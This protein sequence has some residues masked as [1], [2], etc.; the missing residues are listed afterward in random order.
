MSAKAAPLSDCA[1]APESPLK[2]LLWPEFPW[3]RQEHIRAYFL[4]N[5]FLAIGDV[6]IAAQLYSQSAYCFGSAFW[7]VGCVCWAYSPA[8]VLLACPDPLSLKRVRTEWSLLLGIVLWMVAC[9]WCFLP[10]T[11]SSLFVFADGIFLVGSILM[12]ISTACEMSD[13]VGEFPPSGWLGKTRPPSFLADF[14]S[15]CFYVAA[16]VL[17]MHKDSASIEQLGLCMWLP[18]SL[19]GLYSAHE[20]LRHKMEDSG[21]C[22]RHESP[23]EYFAGQEHFR[24]WFFGTAS[25][26]LGSACFPFKLY[27][28]WCLWLGYG[29]WIVGCVCFTHCPLK[30]MI[31]GPDPF[32]VERAC[33][34]WC[35]I[36][37]MICW[38]VGCSWCF[39]PSTRDIL[40]LDADRLLLVGAILVL[41]PAAYQMLD[42]IGE[43]LPSRWP[44]R[45]RPPGF[46][47]EFL[48]ACFFTAAAL[49]GTSA[50]HGLVQLGLCLWFPGAALGF[51][52]AHELLK[53]NTEEGRK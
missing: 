31:S 40:R 51:Y 9:A 1:A 6:F 45:A 17:E 4:S 42:R 25:L 35:K 43:V 44:G 48:A 14:L 23:W 5:V 2:L 15:S 19:L 7:I 21:A 22:S 33:N 24:A 3:K 20:L 11:G 39:P 26:S 28:E 12:F 50:S 46:V 52:T 38:I 16:S 49:L 34:E 47:V 37:G 32:S 30:E 29:F 18:G 13:R 10:K 36:L 41:I 27:L 8:K 53:R